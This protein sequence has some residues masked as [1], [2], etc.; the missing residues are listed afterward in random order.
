[1]ELLGL[2][3]T[4]TAGDDM[5]VVTDERKA[6]EIAQFRQGK[7]REVRLAKSTNCPFRRYF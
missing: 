1:M 5:M 4:P 6:R 3:G 2:S 7:Y